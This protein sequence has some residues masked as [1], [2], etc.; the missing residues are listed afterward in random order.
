VRRNPC[1]GESLPAAAKGRL[2][3]QCA[4]KGPLLLTPQ[5]RSL[6]WPPHTLACL[7]FEVGSIVGHRG[8]RGS[9]LAA[10]QALTKRGLSPSYRSEQF[11]ASWGTV[12]VL[13]GPVGRLRLVLRGGGAASRFAVFLSFSRYPQSPALGV[14]QGV[15]TARWRCLRGLPVFLS[16]SLPRGRASRICSIQT[17][18]I[19][20][21]RGERKGIIDP[22]SDL[23]RNSRREPPRPAPRAAAGGTAGPCRRPGPADFFRDSRGAPRK[24]P[25]K[26]HA[27]V[28]A[29][30]RA[31]T[32]F[33][34]RRA[35]YSGRMYIL[36]A[37]ESA[38]R[39][40]K[41]RAVA[42]QIA[43]A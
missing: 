3:P 15:P 7:R 43:L 9:A 25:R 27:G 40:P 29:A 26:G 12:P 32:H 13:L 28:F 31:K 41:F 17:S 37:A 14:Q 19:T 42:W 30:H 22:F 11:R 21:S 23:A 6:P 16:F 1:C 36:R 10:L 2:P 18:T 4:A 33:A 5:V 39:R 34:L 8:V 38:C 20:Y 35:P 24:F